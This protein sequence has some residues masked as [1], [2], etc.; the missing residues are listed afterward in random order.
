MNTESK[1]DTKN[2]SGK[3]ILKS[4]NVVWEIDEKSKTEIPIDRIKLIAEYTTANGPFI[5][6][7]FLVIYNDKSE[8]FEISMYAENIQ[9]M[10]TELGKS[11]NFELYGS[12]AASADWKSNIIYPTEYSGQNLWNIVKTEPKSTFDKL[13]SLIGINKT[14]LRLTEVAEKIIN[15]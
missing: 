3:T 4:G 7:W 11:M 8:Y 5:D 15:D 10:M 13:K 9:E 12:L 6:D 14:E 2:Q 1:S